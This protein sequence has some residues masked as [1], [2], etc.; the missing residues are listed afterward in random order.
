[1]IVIAATSAVMVGAIGS[2]QADRVTTSTN[3]VLRISVNGSGLDQPQLVAYGTARISAGTATIKSVTVRIDQGEPIPVELDGQGNFRKG[4]VLAF[5]LTS[6]EIEAVATASD[7]STVNAVV[8][9]GTDGSVTRPISPDQGK[10]VTSIPNAG[11][12]DPPT[13]GPVGL[14]LVLLGALLVWRNRRPREA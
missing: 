9:I 2:A 11:M 7:G 13:L 14:A 6:V 8:V 4:V 12:S 10:R 1:M 3:Q 5:E